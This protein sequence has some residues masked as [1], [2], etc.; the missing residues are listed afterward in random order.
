MAG[1]KNVGEIVVHPFPRVENYLSVWLRAILVLTPMSLLA[2]VYKLCQKWGNVR[3]NGEIIRN[4]P[5][6]LS[7]ADFDTQ[8]G[9]ST[10]HSSLFSSP[11]SCTFNSGHLY[12]T[13]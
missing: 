11:S 1:N 6:K 9:D 7:E 4:S 13:V 8:R 5:K 3:N 2:H 12:D 10:K